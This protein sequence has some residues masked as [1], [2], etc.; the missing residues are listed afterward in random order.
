M[1][2]LGLMAFT[3]YTAKLTTAG[4]SSLRLP[5][6]PQKAVVNNHGVITALATGGSA[7][8]ASGANAVAI[9]YGLRAAYA[10]VTNSGAITA[11]ANAGD[12]FNAGAYGLY[13]SSEN[14]LTNTG[15]IRAS[16]DMAYE[17]LVVS[18]TTTLVDTYNVALDG[19]PTQASL[20]VTDG[21]TL[22]LNDATLTTTAIDGETLWD[23]EYRLFETE[24]TGAVTGSFADAQAVNPN[25][26]VIY[27][28]QA[29]VDSADDTVALA[30]A[31]TA[32]AASA[33]AR[34]EKQVVSQ[35]IDIVKTH[36]TTTLLQ[37]VLSPLS[38]PLLADAG[39][40]V[41]TGLGQ[42]PF[43]SDAGVFVE[44]Y[45]SRIDKDADPLGYDATLWG[46]SG[47]YERHIENSLVGLHLS[48]GRSDIDYTG[49]GHASNSEDQDVLTGGFTG[50]T[51]WDEWTLRYGASVFYGWHDYTGLTGLSLDEREEA[52]YDSYGAVASVM[53]G[54]IM[55]RGDQVFLP[56]VG[57]NYLWSHRQRYTTE[58]TDPG[59]NTTY[60][61]M[62]EH[63]V[64]A[65]AT[66]RWLSGFMHGDMH[67]VPSV[68][69]GVRHLLTD[70][71]SSVWQSVPGASPVLVTS[72]R[73]RTALTLSGSVALT[74]NGRAL[75]LAYDGEY[76]DDAR[77]H[78]FWLRYSWPF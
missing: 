30:Y 10:D 28:D 61:A 33:S 52:C 41:P 45:Y 12:G 56:E 8:S 53:A 35:A 48:Y 59:W 58:A 49:P 2:P 7:E 6:G 38:S 37:D 60:S 13:F 20:G 68:A 3:P 66:L 78:N 23:T 34:A 51:R 21:A 70:A 39:S 54:H 36:M 44:P 27:Y 26:S 73:D 67:V 72:E 16:G 50:L 11:T 76:S 47:G 64:Q 43:D 22:A 77:R 57:L 29:T 18:G 71:E 42:G 32:S 75:L 15:I 24:G 31:P 63:D 55:R 19:D 25:T 17:V 65:E 62:S 46:F 4:P 9:A 74:K 69:V 5:A 40:V 14:T 1:L